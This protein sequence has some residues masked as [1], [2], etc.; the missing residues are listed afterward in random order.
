MLY[1]SYICEVFF[2]HLHKAQIASL[3]TKVEVDSVEPSDCDSESRCISELGFQ[4]EHTVHI[5][6]F[7]LC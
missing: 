2:R 6:C 5:V 1:N 4:V 7:A 3:K